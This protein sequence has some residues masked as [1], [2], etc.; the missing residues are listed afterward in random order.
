MALQ[1]R[2]AQLRDVPMESTLWPYGSTSTSRR[3]RQTKN[4]LEQ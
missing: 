4:D 1:R 3:K 2:W